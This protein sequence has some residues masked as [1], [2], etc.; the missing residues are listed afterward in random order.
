MA[1]LYFEGLSDSGESELFAYDGGGVPVDLTESLPNQGGGIVDGSDNELGALGADPGPSL[2]SVGSDVFFSGND[3]GL[4]TLF[5]YSESSGKVTALDPAKA[6]GS[7]VIPQDLTS[8][9][10]KVYFVGTNAAGTDTLWKSNGTLAGTKE[11]AGSPVDIG[12]MTLLGST[13]YFSGGGHLKSYNTAT[14]VFAP[15]AHSAGLDPQDT[16]AAYS[17][18]LSFAA[19]THLFM[20]GTNSVGQQNIYLL[21]AGSLVQFK[22]NVY[23]G[24]MDPHDLTAMSAEVTASGKTYDDG[25][26]YFSGVDNGADDRGLYF[27]NSGSAGHQ[28]VELASSSFGGSSSGLDPFDLTAFD[29]ELYFTGNDQYSSGRGLFAYDPNGNTVTEVIDSNALD[30]TDGYVSAWGSAN[31]P[32]LGVYDGKLYFGAANPNAVGA[33]SVN[34][35]WSLSGPGATATLVSVSGDGT[36]FG[37]QPAN[38]V[39]H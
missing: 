25:G 7:G 3:D 9:G 23:A 4:D 36:T 14:G 12:D 5:F 8:V 24:G 32:T 19:N 30:L 37:G 22:S 35:L 28:A 6:W 15:I 33:E 39:S 1:E 10:S 31:A 34:Q 21:K 29:G 11:V 16:L 26:V 38:L 20:A 13:L 17:S 27:V 2:V 18:G